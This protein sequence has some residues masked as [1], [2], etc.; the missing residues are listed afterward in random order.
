VTNSL[1]CAFAAAKLTVLMRSSFLVKILVKQY[2]ARTDFAKADTVHLLSGPPEDLVRNL[3]CP[4]VPY[5]PHSNP[6]EYGPLD[7][8][9]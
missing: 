5:H 7:W 4:F 8:F 9:I 1:R 3:K 2:A 6:R